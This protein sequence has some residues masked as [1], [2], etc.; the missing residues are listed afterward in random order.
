MVTQITITGCPRNP[1]WRARLILRYRV[2]RCRKEWVQARTDKEP[3]V[4]SG[5]NGRS[6]VG[7]NRVSPATS[8]M[9]YFGLE[10]LRTENLLE[11]FTIDLPASIYK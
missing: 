9:S 10:L 7:G 3:R 11:I 8:N 5:Y 6:V 2:H 1:R 4:G